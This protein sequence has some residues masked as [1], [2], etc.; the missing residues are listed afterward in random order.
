MTEEVSWRDS[1]TDESLKMAPSLLK[2]DSVEALGKAYLEMESYQGRSIRIPDSEASA[3]DHRDFTE[4]LMKMAPGVVKKPI[5]DDV[6]SNNAFWKGMG[7]PD[8]KDGYKQ[9]E[10]M[11]P[12][13]TDFMRDAAFSANMTADQFSVLIGKMAGKTV[14]DKETAKFDFDTKKAEL[15]KEWGM[16]ADANMNIINHFVSQIDM[17][18]SIKTELPNNPDLKRMMLSFAKKI[19]GEG[20]A[21]QQQIGE[22]GTSVMSPSEASEKKQAIMSNR[23]HAYW[24]A[25]DPGHKA[26]VRQVVDLGFYAAGQNPG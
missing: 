22:N 17:P 21:M 25:E 16:A 5:A 9:I 8:D 13:Q 23:D 2:Y 7:R 18:E 15:D 3:G 4:K 6:E 1:L 19:G 11:T 26:A 20:A 10:G 14:I 24:R 12:E